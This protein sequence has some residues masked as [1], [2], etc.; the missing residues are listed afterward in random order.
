MKEQLTLKAILLFF[1]PLIFMSELIQL[2]HVITN[3]FLARLLAPKEIIAAFSIAFGLNIMASGVTMATIQTGI[4][5]IT[6]QTSFRR[7][8]RFC[9]LLVLIPFFGVE[10]IALSPAGE[11]VFGDWM[12]ASPGVVNQARWAAAIMGFWT[13]PI[14]IRNLCYAIA[15][16]QRRTILITY[17]TAVRL[18]GLIGFLFVFSIW[19]DGAVV[20]AMATVAGMTVEATFMV[21]ATR[22]YYLKLKKNADQPAGAKEFW[23]FSWPLMLMQITENGVMTV[24]N[25]FLGQLRNP[26]LAIASFGIVYG[27]VRI[28]LAGPRNLVQTSQSLVHGRGDLRAMFQ[29]TIGLILFYC[30]LIFL[31]FYTPLNEWILGTVMGLTAE[32]SGYCKNAVK[33][34]FLIAIFW[35][36]T[37][38]LRGTLTSMRKTF[39]IAVSAGVRMVVIAAI[40]FFAFL[41]PDLNGAV[42][43]VFSFAGAF[44]AETIVLGWYLW[45]QVRSDETLF[46]SISAS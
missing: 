34:I 42:L 7:L 39:V 40:G 45:H 17:A 12:G 35:A 6:D 33:L 11:I 38:T 37:A 43:G 13:F 4:C 1:L 36:T 2:S 44:A 29:F 46:D 21:V 15:M 23:S 9:L 19:F 41:Y 31:L 16:N 20:G 28:I 22:S 10:F 24:L 25:L 27:L 14:L 3:A 30:G 8:L 5:F 18:V 32:L 26:D